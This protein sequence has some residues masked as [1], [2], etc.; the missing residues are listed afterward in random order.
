MERCSY[1]CLH[2]PFYIDIHYNSMFRIPTILDA[3]ELLDKAFG[4]AKK[5]TTGTPKTRA[6]GKL[7]AVKKTLDTTLDKYVRAFPSFDSLHPFYREL[8]DITIGMDKLKKSLGA[9]DWARKKVNTISNKAIKKAKRAEDAIQVLKETYGRI[10]SVL[11]QINDHLVFLENARR[12]LRKTPSI[13]METPTVIL[14]GY[15]NVGKSSLLKLLSSAEPV[16]ASYPFTT[17]GLVLGHV[18]IDERYEKRKIQFIEAPGLLD[19]PHEK[20]NDIERQG[21]TALRYLPDLVV[22]IVD[23]SL[24]CGYTL[25]SQLN[26]L[27]EI[28]DEFDVEVIAV[29][30]K[31]D[32]TGGATDF[33]KVSCTTGHGVA[34]LKREIME[35]LELL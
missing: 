17:K 35:K 13:D 19:R 29:E 14:A 11:Y 26:L 27:E 18:E 3:D 9:V 28:R 22:F 23:A 30:N 33:L 34:Q 8:I 5:I 25:E 32:I 16:I 20:R 1:A 10:S 12:T 21:I 24:H 6:V 7:M 15:P 31:A 4:R 2:T